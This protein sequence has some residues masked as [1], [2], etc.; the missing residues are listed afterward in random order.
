MLNPLLQMSEGF[1][2]PDWD[3]ITA[4]VATSPD[5]REQAAAVCALLEHEYAQ[6]HEPSEQPATASQGG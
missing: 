4:W 5:H 3:A 2:R 1:P 6:D